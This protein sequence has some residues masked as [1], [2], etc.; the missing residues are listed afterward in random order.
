[1]LLADES[2]DGLNVLGGQPFDWWH[3]TERPVMS[4]GAGLNREKKRSVG[5]VAWFVH[6][7]EG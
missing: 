6:L 5:V 4:S 1:M 2:N 7:G 3:V